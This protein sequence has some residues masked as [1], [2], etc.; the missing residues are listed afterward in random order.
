MAGERTPDTSP[1]SK[2][3]S[4]DDEISLREHLQRQLD[5][6]RDNGLRMFDEFRTHYNVLLDQRE[7]H[8]ITRVADLTR[9]Y[10]ERYDRQIAHTREQWDQHTHAT[11]IAFEVAT[12]ATDT[13]FKAA[14]R[15]IEQAHEATNAAIGKV[16]RALDERFSAQA[17]AL[18]KQESAT[19]KRFDAVNEFRAQLSDQAGTFMPRSE[20]EV[21]AQGLTEKLEANSDR[22]NKLE[23]RVSS[24]LDLADGRSAGADKT[25]GWIFAAA[26]FVSTVIA[27]GFALAKK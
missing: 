8:W 19:E 18:S 15:A 26:G 14:N 27:I 17:L 2:A 20:S 21:R 16:E 3:G 24:R 25:I 11:E 6:Q 10:D 1:H 13:A 9:L 4:S 12:A 7:Q 22:I 23:L 5:L